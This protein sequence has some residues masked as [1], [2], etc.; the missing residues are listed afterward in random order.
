MCLALYIHAKY[1]T[2]TEAALHN[3]LADQF[4]LIY[5]VKVEQR[6]GKARSLLPTG[7]SIHI[8][9]SGQNAEED[10]RTDSTQI[11][12]SPQSARASS[13]NVLF[14]QMLTPNTAATLIRSKFSASN[15]ASSSSKKLST[16]S[17]KSGPADYVRAPSVECKGANEGIGGAKSARVS[18]QS[19]ASMDPYLSLQPA[20]PPRT[21][22]AFHSLELRSET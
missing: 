22:S 21:L 6:F 4:L 2:P 10:E 3:A 1:A 16:S 19:T 9:D 15:A 12:S 14:R 18:S 13:S 5:R 11:C 7:A 8:G 20:L 17:V